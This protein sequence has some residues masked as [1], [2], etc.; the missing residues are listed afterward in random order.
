M[1][2]ALP[3]AGLCTL[4]A[5]GT[6]R[7]RPVA[8]AAALLS[9]ASS[10]A[11]SSPL[12]DA[13]FTE[14]VPVSLRPLFGSWADGASP[15]PTAYTRLPALPCASF[16]GGAS[17]YLGPLFFCAN[18]SAAVV[19]ASRGAG[20]VLPVTGSSLPTVIPSGGILVGL[21][22]AA[23]ARTRAT[24]TAA[25]IFPGVGGGVYA[26]QC[27]AAQSSCAAHVLN[28]TAADVAAL[29]PRLAG[30]CAYASASSPSRVSVWVTGT[31][32]TA[33]WDV[34]GVSP[35]DAAAAA[36]LLFAVPW[37][38]T[39]I[40]HSTVLREVT[41]GN[42]TKVTHLDDAPPAAVRRWEWVTD[43]P[44]GA[45]GPYD[46]AVTSLAYDDDG[47]L[48]VGN[49][50]ALNVRSPTGAVTRLARDEGLP[51]GNITALAIVAGTPRLWI[52]TTRGVILY[53][54]SAPLS[55]AAAAPGAARWRYF[56]GPR[57][58]L[59][60]SPTDV[61][62]AS[63]VSALSIDGNET[64]VASALGGVSVLE[65]QAWTLS[66]KA[67]AYEA[68]IPRHSR[69][70]L[71]TQ[72]GLTSFGVTT[73]C[74]NGPD[75]NNGLWT[76]LSV[77]AL[78]LRFAMT[79][80]A[81][82]A[83]AAAD[84]FHA[85]RLL[86]RAPGIPG[87]ISR[88]VVGPGAGPQGDGWHNSTAPGFD[89]WQW[90]GDASSDE[91][92]GHLF[93]YTTVA[94]TIPTLAAEADSAV[95]DL[96]WYITVNNFTLIDVTGAPTTW[97]RWDPATINHVRDNWS[98]TRGLN[99]LQMLAML[100]AGLAATPPGSQNHTLFAAAWRA[101]APDEGGAGYAANTL[102]LKITAPTDDNYSDD[103]LGLFSYASLFQ[104]LGRLNATDPS[105]VTPAQRG[106]LI[107]SLERTRLLLRGLRSSLWD[108][109]FAAALGQASP[110]DAADTLWNL[111][112]WPLSLVDWPAMN[113]HR[114]DVVLDTDGERNGWTTPDSVGVIPANERAQTR[115]NA[116][117]H[118]LDGGSGVDESDPGAFLLMYWSA[119][120]A[121]IVGCCA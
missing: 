54:P 79:G 75:D 99:S 77:A 104:S 36:Q 80:N 69:L 90:K 78:A 50:T 81:S 110:T 15:L 63:E 67:A 17:S 3:I 108:S 82:A 62:A 5:S 22:A 95:V 34:D 71:V 117:P 18:A 14:F 39:A 25:L 20:S 6:S 21:D 102:N 53:D 91:V 101:L 61:F 87:L 23:S 84:H 119:V 65:S 7:M 32:G 114:L 116:N 85:M 97:G 106:A 118:D 72:C 30:G 86:A 76:S 31:G 105:V 46:D 92:V 24:W 37:G 45:G 73:S 88:S 57:Y 120:A 100:A 28:V 58:L 98:D 48:Y 56:Y 9:V 103:E 51:W 113:S 112:T 10:A 12:P 109:I 40:A 93:A 59:A 44:S 11:S 29:P 89:G 1:P 70:G 8:Y 19:Y 49:P 52:G 94:L 43:I 111:R 66:A 47:T 83:A 2:N 68:A 38:A 42:A 26:L 4:H 60:A 96:V 13:A 121:G 55:A 35:W 115:W 107:A 33:A 41:L 74:A 64:H 16:T 27:D